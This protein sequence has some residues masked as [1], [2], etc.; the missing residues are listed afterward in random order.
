[1]KFSE[2]SP[3]FTV[4]QDEH[5]KIIKSIQTLANKIMDK[6]MTKSNSFESFRDCAKSRLDRLNKTSAEVTAAQMYADI[7]YKEC[8]ASKQPKSEC[9]A[10]SVDIFMEY[11]KELL[12]RIRKNKPD[13]EPFVDFDAMR[14]LAE[15]EAEE[16]EA[17]ASGEDGDDDDEDDE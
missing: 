15:Q 2:G 17:E 12:T 3:Y 9:K 6:C 11:F 1:M 8:L 4:M 10:Q 14:E 13:P 5:P 7:K 16:D